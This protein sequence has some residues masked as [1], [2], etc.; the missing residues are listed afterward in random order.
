MQLGEGWVFR[1]RGHLGLRGGAWPAQPDLAECGD[2][3]LEEARR[4][5]LEGGPL[6]RAC[7]DQGSAL[8]EYKLG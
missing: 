6:P 3:A 4:K 1:R 5:G 2:P 7:E 8:R